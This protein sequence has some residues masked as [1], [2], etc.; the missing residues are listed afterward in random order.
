MTEF[1]V[2]TPLHHVSAVPPRLEMW[3]ALLSLTR[4]TPY[5]T[6]TQSMSDYG[7]RVVLQDDI[8]ASSPNLMQVADKIGAREIAFHFEEGQSQ[9]TYDIAKEAMMS[10]AANRRASDTARGLRP[11]Y[12]FIPQ[13]VDVYAWNK[14]AKDFVALWVKLRSEYPHLF[15]KPPIIA[16]CNWLIPDRKSGDYIEVLALMLANFRTK[17]KIEAHLIDWDGEQ[18]IIEAIPFR[19]ISTKMPFVRALDYPREEDWMERQLTQ[20]QLMTAMSYSRDFQRL[21]EQTDLQRGIISGTRLQRG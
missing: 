16:V 11:S 15:L 17:Y 3:W 19:S 13:G 20:D 5:Y 2:V 21:L 12:I 9:E 1:A 7:K 18:D 14:C 6:H 4:H 8:A 10:I